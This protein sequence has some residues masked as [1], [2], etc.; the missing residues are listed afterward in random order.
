MQGPNASLRGEDTAQQLAAGRISVEW[1]ASIPGLL[2]LGGPS[3]DQDDI[4]SGA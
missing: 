4:S 2:C 1:R 3:F